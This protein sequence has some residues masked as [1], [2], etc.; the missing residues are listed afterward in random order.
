MLYEPARHTS[1]VGKEGELGVY[2]P[3]EEL[4]LGFREDRDFG[5]SGGFHDQGTVLQR[6][7][8]RH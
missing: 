4:G 5:P 3:T 2:G 7:F 1:S 6:H 8:E